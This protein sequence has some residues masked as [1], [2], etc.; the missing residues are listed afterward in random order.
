MLLK[1]IST[2]KVYCCH[3][4]IDRLSIISN[5]RLV[6]IKTTTVYNDL[7]CKQRKQYY[8]PLL[9]NLRKHDRMKSIVDPG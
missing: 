6:E 3:L 7:K 8:D 2:F 5:L 1:S 9:T 4:V